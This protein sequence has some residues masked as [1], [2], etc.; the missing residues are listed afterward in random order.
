LTKRL[1]KEKIISICQKINQKIILI[2]GKDVE[3]E[4]EEIA[5]IS[6][7]NI[8][9]LCGKLSLHES[10]KIIQNAQK[11]I[12]HDTGMM[13]IAAAFQKEIISIWGNT[14]PA[15]GM[16]PF[17]KKSVKKNVGIEVKNLPC[18]PCSK[19]GF[20]KCP[21]GHFKCMKEID[22]SAVIELLKD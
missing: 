18:R 12:T 6:G 2:G 4:G 17:Y 5:Q 7:Q 1:P 11:V 21:K 15:F 14:I 3:K 20:E 22:V 8:T 10:A 19:I 13:H 9:N 16:Y